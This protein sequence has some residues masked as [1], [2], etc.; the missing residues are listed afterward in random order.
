MKTPPTQ[1]ENVED[2]RDGK[3]ISVK[4]RLTLLEQQIDTKYKLAKD[5]GV[6]DI[7]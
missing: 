7:K 5:A 2:R 1:S 3:P 4:P 6:D